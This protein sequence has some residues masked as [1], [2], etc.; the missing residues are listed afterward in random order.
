MSWPTGAAESSN[1]ETL[2]SSSR[3]FLDKGEAVDVLQ[4][5][6]FPAIAQTE[7]ARV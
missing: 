3:H 1:S 5:A 2:Q 6:R 7:K 4:A